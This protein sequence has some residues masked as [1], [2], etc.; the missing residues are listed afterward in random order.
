MTTAANALQA[1]LDHLVAERERLE[2]CFDLLAW[3]AAKDG[4]LDA[5]EVRQLR[6][7]LDELMAHCARVDQELARWSRPRVIASDGVLMG[8]DPAR[9]QLPPAGR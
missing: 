5:A 2:G 3:R 1:T 8:P 9:P 6:R 7:V 4:Q